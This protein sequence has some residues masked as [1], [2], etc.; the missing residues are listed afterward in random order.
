MA[1][2]RVY[3]KNE[4]LANSLSHA[5]GILLGIVAAFILL[6][7]TLDSG[8]KW[9]TGSVCIY[10]FGMLSCYV[11]STS[12][13]ACAVGV[14]KNILQKF[15]HA[16]IYL[17]IAGTYTPF[18]LIVL[19]DQGYWGWGLSTF[20]WLAALVGVI[21]SF[22]KSGKHSYIE[23]ACYVVMGCSILVAFKPLITI[24]SSDGEIDSLYWLIAGGISY[25]IG[26]LFYSWAK[27]PYMHTVFHFFVLGGSICHIVAIYHIL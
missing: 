17:H 1:R 4:E 20:I 16:S 25:I 6:S 5:A 15:D 21:V 9:A 23:T 24:L 11:I 12:Y 19:R 14:R 18:T 27:K 3:S 22:R 26:A 13:H 7:A 2:S 8:S 10:L